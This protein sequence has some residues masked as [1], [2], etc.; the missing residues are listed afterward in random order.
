MDSLSRPISKLFEEENKYDYD[1]TLYCEILSYLPFFE[2][3]VE[4]DYIRYH[5]DHTFEYTA[6][7]YSFI[8]ALFDS[9]LV[10]EVDVMTEFLEKYNSS[11]AYKMWIKDMNAVLSNDKYMSTSNLSFIRKAV[12]SMI[13][14]EKVMPGSWGIDVETGNWLKILKQLQSILPQIYQCRKENMN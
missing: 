10:E 14:L 1:I 11:S 6:Q 8:K 9:K 3:I 5:D 12:F 13:K 4:K 2:D 7:F